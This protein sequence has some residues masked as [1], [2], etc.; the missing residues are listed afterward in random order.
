MIIYCNFLT[1][2]LEDFEENKI[3]YD[4]NVGNAP[5]VLIP[6]AVDLCDISS[7]KAEEDK[8]LKKKLGELSSIAMKN[9]LLHIIDIPIDIL[10][11]AWVKAKNQLKISLN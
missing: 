3:Q 11:P 5:S 1:Y 10:I 4:N 7:I 8:F 6:G 9:G 2:D